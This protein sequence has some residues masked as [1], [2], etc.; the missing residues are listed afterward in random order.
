MARRDAGGEARQTGELAQAELLAWSRELLGQRRGLHRSQ[1]TIDGVARSR[2]HAAGVG[3]RA[4]LV[5]ASREPGV[6]FATH[7]SPVCG[8]DYLKGTRSRKGAGYAPSACEYRQIITAK[9]VIDGNEQVDDRRLGNDDGYSRRDDTTGNDPINGR[10]F[11]T[12]DRP[13]RKV[14]LVDPNGK[15][16]SQQSSFKNGERIEWTFTF[17]QLVIDTLTDRAVAKIGPHTVTVTGTFPNLTIKG[18]DVTLREPTTW[19]RDSGPVFT[20]KKKGGSE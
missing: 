9:L 16:V 19:D 12:I 18:D 7:S 20:A 11:H 17:T 8:K 3:D 10:T 2:D 15:V 14:N 6:N 1:R 4:G 13:G 5:V